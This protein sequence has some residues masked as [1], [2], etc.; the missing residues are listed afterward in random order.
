MFFVVK[1]TKE[2]ALPPK[3]FG[4]RLRS[5]LTKKLQDEAE[6]TCSTQ[7]GIVVFVYDPEEHAISEGKINEDTGYAHFM[8][9]CRAIVCRPFNGEVVEAIVKSV[10]DHGVIATVGPFQVF[11]SNRNMPEGSQYDAAQAVYVD[12]ANVRVAG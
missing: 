9:T 12:G 11:I 8:V 5:M 3:Y 6:G 10:N 7:H 1:L 4:P 2:V